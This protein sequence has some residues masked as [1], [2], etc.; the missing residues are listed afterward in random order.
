MYLGSRRE[1]WGGLVVVIFGG[2][3]HV[4]FCCSLDEAVVYFVLWRDFFEVVM[5]E[6]GLLKIEE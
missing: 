3:R 1:I 2:E 4:W 5:S 6:D